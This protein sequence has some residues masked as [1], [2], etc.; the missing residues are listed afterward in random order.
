MNRGGTLCVG[1]I[2]DQGG[3]F[4]YISLEAGAG[5]AS[6]AADQGV[7]AGDFKGTR[8]GLCKAL[9]ERRASIDPS[10]AIAERFAVASVFTAS[11]RNGS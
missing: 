6:L 4:S 5:E 8:P 10:G 3:L 2:R 1:R 9:F 7:G 11:A